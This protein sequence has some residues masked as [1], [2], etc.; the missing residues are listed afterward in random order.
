MV[1]SEEMKEKNLT[2]KY[3]DLYTNKEEEAKVNIEDKQSNLG[4]NSK[5]A[6]LMQLKL[7]Y[8]RGLKV[9]KYNYWLEVMIN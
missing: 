8:Y 9:A 1:S 7:E 6:F 2:C 3:T 4:I 5:H